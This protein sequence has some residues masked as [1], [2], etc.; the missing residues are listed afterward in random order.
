MP[1]GTGLDRLV[2]VPLGPG[3][4]RCRFRGDT[5][6]NAV[7]IKLMMNSILIFKIN[8][9]EKIVNKNVL[10]SFYPYFRYP[11]NKDNKIAAFFFIHS[12]N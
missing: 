8:L 4:A 7:R 3:A 10:N 2:P 12:K 6:R 9:V 1:V 5:A 11:D